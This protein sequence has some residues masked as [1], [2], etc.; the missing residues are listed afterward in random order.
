MKL[1]VRAV[2]IPK[3]GSGAFEHYLHGITILKRQVLTKET[4]PKKLFIMWRL[5]GLV[6]MSLLPVLA[7]R[8][9]MLC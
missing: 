9:F 6:K 5:E 4:G 7:H 1:A 2:I 3:T 8:S